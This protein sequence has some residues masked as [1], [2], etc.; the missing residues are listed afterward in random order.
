[1]S[2]KQEQRRY[3]RQDVH[4]REVSGCLAENVEVISHP[5]AEKG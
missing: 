5:Y 2:N 4:W 3:Q 1:M